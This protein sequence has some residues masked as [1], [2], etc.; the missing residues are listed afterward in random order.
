MFLICVILPLIRPVL[1][2]F[3][4]FFRLF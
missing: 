4:C 3:I 2:L 1:R